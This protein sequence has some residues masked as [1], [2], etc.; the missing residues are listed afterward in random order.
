MTSRAER[1]REIAETLSVH[2]F[3]FVVGATGPAGRFPFRRGLPGHE[4]GRI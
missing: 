1:Y 3:G 4:K 2:G